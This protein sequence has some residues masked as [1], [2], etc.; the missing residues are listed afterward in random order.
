MGDWRRVIVVGACARADVAQLRS[1]LDPG[2]DYENFHCLVNGGVCGLPDWA[3]EAIHAV[4]NLAERNHGPEDVRAQLEI[5]A[6]VAPSLEVKVHCGDHNEGDACVATI[7][8]RAGVASVGPPEIAS[9]PR[10]TTKQMAVNM[11]SQIARAR[12]L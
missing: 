11:I 9:V 4:G 5:L 7:S 3:A 2:P 6:R 8:L 10:Q 12:R 1:A